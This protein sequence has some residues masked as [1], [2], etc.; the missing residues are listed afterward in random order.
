[1]KFNLSKTKKIYLKYLKSQETKNYKFKNKIEQF[2]KFYVPLSELIYKRYLKKK[3]TTVVGLSGGQGIGKSTIAHILKII[4]KEK[5]N[6]KITIFSIDDFYKTLADRKSMSYRISKLFQTRGV[7]GTHDVQM[8]LNCL[9]KLKKKSFKKILIPKFDKSTD[10]RCKKNKWTK[11]LTKPHIVIFEGWCVGA[12]AQ[13]NNSLIKPINRLERHEDKKM[14]W[15]KKTNFE[16]QSSYKKIFKLI[17]FLIY[18]KIPSFNYVYKWRLIQEKKLKKNTK[19]KKIMNKLQLKRFIMF[20]ERITR[21]MS[22]TAKTFSDV[23]VKVDN[24]HRL[25]SIE[26]N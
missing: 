8:L 19:G 17:D 22:K 11:V 24:Q 10:N 25:K 20:Y 4:I 15:R 2:E 16:L 6:L 12:T 3:T 5:Y 21:H 1:M 18:L 14:I 26:I 7:P 9:K 23:L 13:Q